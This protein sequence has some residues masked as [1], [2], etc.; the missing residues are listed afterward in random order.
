VGAI[1]NFKLMEQLGDMAMNCYRMRH[2]AAAGT[3]LLTSQ[4]E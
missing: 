4:P 1:A 3:P 2:F